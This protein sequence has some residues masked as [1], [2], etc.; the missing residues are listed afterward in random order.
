MRGGFYDV[1]VCGCAKMCSKTR[2]VLNY[3]N[4][5]MQWNGTRY[6]KWY[7][8][9]LSLVVVFLARSEGL[10]TPFGLVTSFSLLLNAPP[11]RALA[12][13][14]YAKTPFLEHLSL[15]CGLIAPSEAT[16]IALH[17]PRLTRPR[18][19]DPRLYFGPDCL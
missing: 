19:G 15:T 9:Q 3:K 6:N 10:V 18:P 2:I 11:A 14:G 5:K 13:H 12:C 4:Y 1:N 8:S 17:M 7:R 16:F